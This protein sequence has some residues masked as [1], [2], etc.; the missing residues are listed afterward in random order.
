MHSS[1]AEQ[2]QAGPV[3]APTA[4]SQLIAVNVEYEVLLCLGNGC[5]KAVNPAG[6]VEHLR[7]IHREKPSV[8]R[9][10][11]EFVAGIPWVY[12]YSTIR[13]PANRSAPQPIIPIVDGFQCRDCPYTT[14]D[15]SN[16]RKHANATHAKKGVKDEELFQAA[17]L[18]SWFRDGK[19]R[20][21]VVDEGP[22]AARESQARRAATRDVGELSDDSEAN[23]GS[24]SGSGS[25]SGS[26]GGDS[27]DSDDEIDQ[28]I[29]NWE[30]EAKERRLQA[31]KNVP[32]AEL[33]SWLQYT[34]WNEV[35]S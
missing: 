11:Q 21:W 22:Q 30:A 20:Y 8:R 28:E 13:L 9:Q 29:E 4:L 16:I 25:D 24:G 33:D 17:R 32:A 19:E 3:A 26:S 6:I 15:R 34:G 23:A 12:N 35:L 18:Q 10:V 2:Q 31:L 5:R 7:K 1:M 27:D 14:T